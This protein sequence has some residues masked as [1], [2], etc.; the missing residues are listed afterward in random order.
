MDLVKVQARMD[1]VCSVGMTKV[2]KKLPNEATLQG[3]LKEAAFPQIREPV[4]HLSFGM[5]VKIGA[6]L[7]QPVFLANQQINSILTQI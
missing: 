3:G 1:M 5:E 4:P 7:S 2:V 6:P